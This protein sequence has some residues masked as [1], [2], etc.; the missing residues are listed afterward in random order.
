MDADYAVSKT[1]RNTSACFGSCTLVVPRPATPHPQVGQSFFI[2]T[3]FRFSYRGRNHHNIREVRVLP[4]ED[5]NI[6]S[7]FKD[8]SDD[9]AYDVTVTY[10]L[11]PAPRPWP[12]NPRP[13]VSIQSEA[14]SDSSDRSIRGG[15]TN[16]MNVPGRPE[17]ERVDLFLKGFRARYLDSD[18]HLL[19]MMVDVHDSPVT[20]FSM[21]MICERQWRSRSVYGN[22]GSGTGK[23][24]V[25]R[26]GIT[27]F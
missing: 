7:T 20:V 24:I 10:V 1:I 14:V 26:L 11:V 2:L 21:T 27:V 9:H 13:L 6:E 12:E 5:G 22:T 19:R 25:T 17:F 15:A 8:D 3:G 23:T 18:E 16:V 4:D